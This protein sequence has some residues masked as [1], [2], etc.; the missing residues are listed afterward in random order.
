MSSDFHFLVPESFHRKFGSDVY[1][2]GPIIETEL[3]KYSKVT[4]LNKTF[5]H[6]KIYEIK[7]RL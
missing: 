6:S 1:D 7:H 4:N 3:L 2:L 5:L